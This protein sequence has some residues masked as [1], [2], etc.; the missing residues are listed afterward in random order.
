MR[1]STPPTSSPCCQTQRPYLSQ[2]LRHEFEFSQTTTAVAGHYETVC[3]Y[4]GSVLKDFFTLVIILSVEDLC[5]AFGRRL[6]PPDSALVIVHTTTT[7]SACLSS[8]RDEEERRD[9]PED[10]TR[11]KPTSSSRLF[12]AS[13]RTDPAHPIS[14]GGGTAAAPRQH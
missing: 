9:Q 7:L 2:T 12:P 11:L 14:R 1:F 4:F 10:K 6:S 8:C 13:C 5:T 3:C